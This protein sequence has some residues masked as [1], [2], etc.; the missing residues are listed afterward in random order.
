MSGL[1]TGAETENR[2]I[3]R[4]LDTSMARPLASANYGRSL[5]ADK[6]NFVIPRET[7]VV[8]SLNTL[9]QKLFV[10]QSRLQR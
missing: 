7:P 9:K 1:Q 10:V 8:E 2:G 5:L 3:V 6:E 4:S